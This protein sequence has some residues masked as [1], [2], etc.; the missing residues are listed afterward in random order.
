M[1]TGFCRNV[2]EER[3]RKDTMISYLSNDAVNLTPIEMHYAV[4]ETNKPNFML[5][6]LPVKGQL[7]VEAW[8]EHLGEYWDQQLLHQI[9]WIRRAH[10]QKH[11]SASK[12][13][14][15]KTERK[16]WFCKNFQSNTCTHQKDHEV[17][18]RLNKH[19][20]L[21]LDLRKAVKP[22]REKV[23]NKTKLKK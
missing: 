9:D 7:N 15:A 10:T 13:S 4:R 16:P 1:G 6:R 11:I 20:C 18:G 14:W 5:A 2:L 22:L 21:L 19:I 12:S 3:S 8:C 17:N 23:F